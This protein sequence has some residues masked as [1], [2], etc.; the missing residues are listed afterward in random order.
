MGELKRP[1]LL[2][3][4]GEVRRRAYP[5][6]LLG[7][8]N[9]SL[10]IL[11]IETKKNVMNI[12]R[13]RGYGSDD[14]MERWNCHSSSSVKFNNLLHRRAAGNNRCLRNGK[15]NTNS[16]RPGFVFGIEQVA[17]TESPYCAGASDHSSFYRIGSLEQTTQNCISSFR[18]QLI[19]PQAEVLLT[20]WQVLDLKRFHRA[21]AAQDGSIHVICAGRAPAAALAANAFAS[22]IACGCDVDIWIAAQQC[23]CGLPFRIGGRSVRGGRMP[24]PFEDVLCHALILGA[25]VEI[26]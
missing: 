24:A 11:S 22:E 16:S 7:P 4:Q 2:F 1:T 13:K 6:R 5:P 17:F 12:S 9:F 20:A 26:L 18:L 19:C 15:D 3:C 10:A 21:V 14:K 25:S 23:G 8:A